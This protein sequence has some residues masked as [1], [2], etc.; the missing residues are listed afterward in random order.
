MAIAGIINIVDLASYRES[1][2]IEAKKAKA[3]IPGSV[4]ETYSSF[5]NTEGGIILLGV[6]ELQD[7]SL[8]A[9]G[10]EDVQ[11]LKQDFWNQIN[12]PQKVSVNILLEKM[13]HEERVDEKDILVIEVPRADRTLRPIYIGNNP[14]SGTY[15][16]NGDGDY[17]C[18]K[19]QVSAMLR[20]ASEVTQDRRVLT[21]MDN[22]IF[23]MDTVKDYRNRFQQLHS[24]HVWNKDDDE[25]FLRHLGAIALSKDDQKFHPTVAGLLMFGYDYEITRELPHYFLDYREELDPQL[26]WTHRLV[27]NSGD[28]SGNLYDFFFRVYPRLAA[29][30]P[31]PFALQNGMTRI[32]EPASHLAVREF[33]LN[34]LVHAD[35]YGRQGIVIRRSLTE[36]HFANPG[37]FRVDL[38]SALQGGNS[39]PRNTFVMKMFGLVG[40]GDRAGSGMPDAIAVM[41]NE[42]KGKV[43][44]TVTHDPDRT[45]LDVTIVVDDKSDDKATIKSGSD[46]KSDDKV[47]IKSESDDKRTIILNFIR[48]NGEVKTEDIATFVG[49]G[50]TRVKVLL[51]EL[52]EEGLIERIG[53]NRNRTYKIKR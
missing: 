19:E 26:R 1:N 42:L 47:T 33:L 9:A 23:C 49:L 40:V 3:Q 48:E 25:L 13:V 22:T 41:E 2:R 20:D 31:V 51:Y 18:N 37:D 28:W 17:H 5:A 12:N 29:D 21:D 30:I 7:H 39:D 10:V 6:E 34:T 52:L 24:T 44:Y 45:T 50:T 16:R 53:G 14:L 15:R 27:S 32:D 38:E 35:H 8:V 46:D 11:K 36:L 43:N 4:W